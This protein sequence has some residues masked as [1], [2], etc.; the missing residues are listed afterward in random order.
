MGSAG[1]NVGAY[2]KLS[3]NGRDYAWSVR[4]LNFVV[5]DPESKLVIDSV[6]F[7]TSLTTMKVTRNGATTESLLRAYEKKM[8]F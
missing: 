4:G 1:W 2:C 3:V 8:C 6:S 7:D 5:Y